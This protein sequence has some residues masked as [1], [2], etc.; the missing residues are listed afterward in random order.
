M[1]KAIFVLGAA[2][3]LST[4]AIAQDYI[5][6]LEPGLYSIA[7]SVSVEGKGVM[8]D[9][10]SE[11]CLGPQQTKKTLQDLLSEVVEGGQCEITNVTQTIGSAAADGKCYDPEFETHTV[12]RLEGTW[13]STSYS[14]K[15][16]ANIAGMGGAATL[17]SKTEARR[18]G[19][20]P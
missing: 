18:I 3:M 4:S 20:C 12:G 14:V 16:R 11:H 8:L 15:G 19:N 10:Q 7:S 2:L 13:T 1:Q 6:E 5:V 17:T 9:D